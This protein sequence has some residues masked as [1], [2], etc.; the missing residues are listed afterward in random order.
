MAGGK[1]DL[2]CS[3]V[4]YFRGKDSQVHEHILNKGTFDVSK[5]WIYLERLLY[6]FDMSIYRKCFKYTFRSIKHMTVWCKP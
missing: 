5:W 4:R 2:L 6:P 1:V 3:A